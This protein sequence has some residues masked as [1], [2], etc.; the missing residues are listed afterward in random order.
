MPEPRTERPGSAPSGGD[1]GRDA[2]P[3]RHRRVV[4]FAPRSGRLN[5][6]Q[7]RAWAAHADEWLL[8][9]NHFAPGAPFD[10]HRAFGRTGP[11]VLE[12]GSGMGESTAAMAVARPDVDLLAVDVYKPGVAQTLFH[13]ARTGATNVRILRADAVQVLESQIPPARLDEIWLFF[14]D[15]WPKR[16]HIK[17]RLVTESFV[18]LVTS[19]LQSGGVFRMATDWEPYA[20]QMLKSASAVSGLENVHPKWAARPEFRPITRFENRGQGAGRVIFDLEFRRTG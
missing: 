7:K 5:D 6:V 12:I 3:A 8:D 13:L 19:R 4:S 14:P 11:L 10:Q 15:P 1:P 9:A 16:K 20:V 2:E 17:R 18:Q